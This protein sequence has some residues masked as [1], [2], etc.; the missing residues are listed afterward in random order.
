MPRLLIALLASNAQERAP[1]RA[2][3]ETAVYSWALAR[4]KGVFK[5]F[6]SSFVRTSQALVCTRIEST[7]LSTKPAVL[8]SKAQAWPSR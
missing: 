7:D 3:I 5:L 4:A 6:I 8:L 1:R 2:S